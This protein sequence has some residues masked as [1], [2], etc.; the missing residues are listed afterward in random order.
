MVLIKQVP[1]YF[2]QF[3]EFFLFTFFA[4]GYRIG[5]HT[6]IQKKQQAI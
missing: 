6:L 1:V 2:K 3:N 5:R 4:Q